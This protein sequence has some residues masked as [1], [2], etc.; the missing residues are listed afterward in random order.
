MTP[1]PKLRRLDMQRAIVAQDRLLQLLEAGSGLETE[2]VPECP[3]RAPVHRE[4]VPLPAAAIE[5][6]HQLDVEPFPTRMGGNE[7]FELGSE[8]LVPGECKVCLDAL[9]QR[10]EPQLLESYDLSLGE[11]LI[12]H[13]REHGPAPQ[14]KRLTQRH[15]RS[16]RIACRELAPSARD[17]PL[18]PLEI[19]L[20]RLYAQPIA[21]PVRRDAVLAEELAQPVHENLKRIPRGRR[22]LLTP[23]RVDQPVT[24][25]D[26]AGKQKEARQQPRLPPR[27]HRDNTAVVDDLQRPQD[28]ELRVSS[29]RAPNAG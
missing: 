19:E 14:R 11:R 16:V 1:V 3:S 21:G 6:E 7:P 27:A 4:R 29:L 12:G 10:H 5:R 2:L 15:G 25:D 24:G 13:V 20:A 28:Q 9:L 8:N 23:Q 18:E 22:R 26:V 17:E